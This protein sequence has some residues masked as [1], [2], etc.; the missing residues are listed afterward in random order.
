MAL[1]GLY[2][3]LWGASTGYLAARGA[4][5]TFPIISLG[6][7]GIALSGLAFVLTRKARPQPIPVRRPGVELAAVL[8]FLLVYAV[9]FLGWGMGAV[10]AVFPPGREHE[11]LVAGVKLLVHVVAPAVLLAAL[12]ARVAPL[13]RAGVS[14]PGFWPP[15]LVLGAIIFALLAVVSPAL[16]QIAG[17]HASPLTLAW[18]GPA[19]FIWMAIVAGLCEEFLF[20]GVLQSRLSAVLRTEFGAVMIGSLLFALAHFPGLYFRGAPGVDGYSTDALQVA[21]F[22]IATLSPIAVL[23]GTLWARTRSLLL[24][25]LLH[26]AVDT[27]PNMA[28][29]VRTWA[30]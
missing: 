24:V 10:K 23:F 15:L 12:G 9:G 16:K 21:A 26:G 3:A 8:A 22:T 20:R 27:L 1:G 5:W 28:E 17:L 6:I 30:Q 18:A 14:R 25:V 7:F 19:S 13:F 29:F 4:D 2:L 11:L